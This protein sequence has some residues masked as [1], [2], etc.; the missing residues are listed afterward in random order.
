MFPFLRVFF[1]ISQRCTRNE[2]RFWFSAFGTSILMADKLFSELA[3]VEVTAE[4]VFTHR[5]AVKLVAKG[6]GKGGI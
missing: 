1:L 2:K 6:K 3:L 4:C 5:R